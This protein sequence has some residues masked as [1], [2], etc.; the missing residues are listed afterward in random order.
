MATGRFELTF[1][2]DYGGRRRLP[3]GIEFFETTGADVFAIVAGDPL[4]ASTRSDR[5]TIVAPRRLERPC[6]D[7]ERPVG[8]RGRVPR[9]ERGRGV[10][11][12]RARLREEL[13][14][15][16]P[17]Q[18]RVS[19]RSLRRSHARAGAARR[20]RVLRATRRRPRPVLARRRRPAGQRLACLADAGLSRLPQH[21]VRRARRRADRLADAAALAHGRC[22]GRMPPP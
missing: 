18:P 5:S 4:S 21:H 1:V 15:H 16:D 3:S 7:V 12:R 22:T 6:R 10:R 17:A 19:A 13:D 20:H 14:P 9:H 2:Q 8:G 11:G